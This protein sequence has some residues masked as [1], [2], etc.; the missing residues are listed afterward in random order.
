MDNGE[1]GAARKQ[2]MVIIMTT[3]DIRTRMV[4]FG[5]VRLRSLSTTYYFFCVS[6]CK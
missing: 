3:R 1:M 5:F 6:W 2:S 4:P